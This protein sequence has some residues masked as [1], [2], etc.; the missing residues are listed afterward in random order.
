MKKIIILTDSIPRLELH[1][2]FLKSNHIK[3]SHYESLNHFVLFLIQNYNR[4]LHQ[5]KSNQN[6]YL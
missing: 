2:T 5:Y 1:I 6:N 4:I 3:Y